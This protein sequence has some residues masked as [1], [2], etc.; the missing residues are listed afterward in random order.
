MTAT[1][2]LTPRNA[3][4]RKTAGM[5]RSIRVAVTPSNDGNAASTSGR[6]W[7]HQAACLDEDPELFHPVGTSGPAVAQVQQAKTICGRCP[8]RLQCLTEA[9]E[10][11]ASGVWGGLSEVERR[12]LKRRG[13]TRAPGAN[14]NLVPVQIVRQRL[15]QYLNLAADG[16]AVEEIAEEMSVMPSTIRK[17]QELLGLAS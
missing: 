11:G 15:D 10:T 8:V 9:M 7:Q 1:S 17:V 4:S 3:S 5:G 6:G 16:L 14:R 2:A 12:L 13:R